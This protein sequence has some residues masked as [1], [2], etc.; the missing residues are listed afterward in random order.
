MYFCVFCI[1]YFVCVQVHSSTVCVICS[2]NTFTVSP[3]HPVWTD[4]KGKAVIQLDAITLGGNG[5]NS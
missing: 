4:N 3:P 2:G 1:L 5:L